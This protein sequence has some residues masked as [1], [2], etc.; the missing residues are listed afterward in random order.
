M[1][2]AHSDQYYL[3]SLSSLVLLCCYYYNNQRINIHFLAI[4]ATDINI[5]SAYNSTQSQ[6][7]PLILLSLLLLPPPPQ[8]QLVVVIFQLVL[9]FV[10][11]VVYCLL[12]LVFSQ[13]QLATLIL[14]DK[15][16]LASVNAKDRLNVVR[17][18]RRDK[19]RQRERERENKAP[20]Y[21]SIFLLLPLFLSINLFP[22]L[23]VCH[24]S[25]SH[26]VSLKP[27]INNN[28]ASTQKL[29]QPPK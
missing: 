3:S 6:L 13:S 25:C 8:M 18:V 4:F 26:H 24:L 5:Y 19:E 20:F 14:Q 2:D 16:S 15:A 12:N 9:F 29:R 21:N 1:N 10:S 7:L 11:F 22:S 28:T 27:N 17:R 23:P